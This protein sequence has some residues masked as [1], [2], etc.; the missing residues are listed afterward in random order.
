MQDV[1][2]LVTPRTSARLSWQGASEDQL[3]RRRAAEQFTADPQIENFLTLSEVQLRELLKCSNGNKMACSMRCLANFDAADM[4]WNMNWIRTKNR[5]RSSAEVFTLFQRVRAQQWRCVLISHGAGERSATPGRPKSYVAQW[6]IDHPDVIAYCSA[7]RM[8]G[9]SA[10]SMCWS[11]SLRRVK[12]LT[13]SGLVRRV[14]FRTRL[15]AA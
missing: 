5:Q 3:Q 9:G 10:R 12:P 4:L 6:L 14:S 15:N 11:E 8:H 7:Q 2:P 13:A 1:T